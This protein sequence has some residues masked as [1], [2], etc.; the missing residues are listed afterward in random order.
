[1]II[2]IPLN[3]ANI[4][5]IL[6]SNGCEA[7]IVGGCVRDSLLG[8]EPHDWDICTNA[9]PEQVK[10]CVDGIYK[11]IETGIKHGTV[12]ILVD[13]IPYEVTTF[14]TEGEYLDNRHP[15]S[16]EFVNSLKQDLSRRDFTI[17]AMAY[18]PNKGLIDYFNGQED[19]ERK[20]I[21]CVGDP[22]DRFKE[23]ALRIMRALRFASTYEFTI[24]DSANLSIHYLKNTLKNITI[25]R[26]NVEFYKLLCGKGVKWVLHNY[27]D[28]IGVF[29]PEIIVSVGFS[30]HN[31]YHCYDVWEHTINAVNNSPADIVLR[32]TMFFHDIA[33]PICFSLDENNI[34]HFYDHAKLS[35]NISEV[36]MER[37]RFDNETILKVKDLVFYHDTEIPPKRRC[38]KRWLNKIGE[39]QLRLLLLVK[40]ADIEAQSGLN[41]DKR[42]CI[43]NQIRTSIDEIILEQQCFTIKDLKINGR[44]LI[45]LG[46]K[47]GI[48]VGVILHQ[49]IELVIN[50]E[51]N[52]D[53]DVLI[54]KAKELM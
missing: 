6:E 2:N 39:N 3:V 41:Y 15:S 20:L 46:I 32:L 34:G 38:V 53:Y 14:R 50:E 26:I 40:Q 52:N 17:N 22:D 48:Q 35:S 25:E 45:L 51:I 13:G 49:L 9:T 33:K 16:V 27:S 42:L 19:L 1:M 24:A 54:N 28:V 43:L 37:M 10:Q 7:Y 18:H 23:D 11:V 31:P 29:I 4:I 5:N 8:K 47:E 12:S 44:D 30:Q 36:I 21:R